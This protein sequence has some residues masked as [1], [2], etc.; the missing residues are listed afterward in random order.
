MSLLWSFL[1]SKELSSEAKE[2]SS[3]K[4][5]TDWPLEQTAV[6]GLSISADQ[7]NVMNGWN[8]ADSDTLCEP[9]PVDLYVTVTTNYLGHLIFVS[10]VSSSVQM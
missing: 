7:R 8:T 3:G 2:Y 6:T 1:L 5:Y 4:P 10:W 9:L